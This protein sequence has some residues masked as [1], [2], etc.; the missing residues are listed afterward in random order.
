MTAY[1]VSDRPFVSKW[2]NPDWSIVPRPAI[3]FVEFGE[4]LDVPTTLESLAR[5]GGPV[6]ASWAD[7]FAE[8]AYTRDPPEGRGLPLFGKSIVF[9]EPDPRDPHRTCKRIIEIR[10]NGCGVTRLEHF[11]ENPS[12]FQPFV[13]FAVALVG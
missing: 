4:A 7:V 5:Q 11:V 6:L 3:R 2:D 12:C 13:L 10:R 9:L 8:H 1:S